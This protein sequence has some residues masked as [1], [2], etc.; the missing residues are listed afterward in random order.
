MAYERHSRY[1]KWVSVDDLF[2]IMFEEEL[3]FWFFYKFIKA[4]KQYILFMKSAKTP[5][6]FLS[7]QIRLAINTM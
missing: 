4:R 6:C 1:V 2:K 7:V 3:S 5:S